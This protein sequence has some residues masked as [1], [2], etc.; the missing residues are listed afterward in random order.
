MELFETNLPATDTTER[1]RNNK[2]QA[3]KKETANKM[4][5]IPNLQTKRWWLPFLAAAGLILSGC[6]TSM[7]TGT[8]LLPKTESDQTLQPGDTLK[9]NFPSAAN[10]DTVQQV[11]RDGK[12]NLY[13]VGEIKAAE[14]SPAE[15][16]QELR[17]LYSTQLISSNVT[18][19]VVS[20]PQTI[21]VTGAVIRPG[22][23][24]SE[25]ALTALEAVM[26]SG[27]FDNAKA[28]AKAVVILRTEGG[29]TQKY[30]LDLKTVLEGSN[31]APFYLKSYDIV[32]V[33]ERFVFF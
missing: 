32:Y 20:S 18:V 29:T 5:R 33:P 7:P 14:R 6:A 10:L 25:R 17:K 13:M 16:Q 15:L 11:R 21:F 30:T 12:I 27:G 2:S 22:K 28:N 1:R 24:S 8:Q 23:L 4:N 31:T 3:L 26:E 19:T 9:F